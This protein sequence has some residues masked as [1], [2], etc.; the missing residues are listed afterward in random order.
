MLQP[1]EPKDDDELQNVNI[2]N[3][4]GSHDVAAPDIPMD[5]MIQLLRIQKINIGSAENPKFSN[6]RDYWEEE[7]MAKITDLLHQFQDLFLTR[8]SEMK[9]ILEDLGEMKIMLKLDAKPVQ[10]RPYRLNP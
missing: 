6:V 2:P 9:G 3:F 8:F 4:E 1:G 7:T 5:S 10:Q